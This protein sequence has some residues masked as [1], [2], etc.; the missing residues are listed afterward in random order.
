[1]A[2]LGQTPIPEAELRA[3]SAGAMSVESEQKLRS[4]FEH[5]YN[6]EFPAGRDL[7]REV[8]AAEP[9]SATAR[10]FLASAL[11]YEILARQGTLQ[12]HLFVTSNK[13]LGQSRPLPDPEFKRH[14]QEVVEEAQRLARQR[15][16]RNPSDADGLFALGLTYANLANYA[17]AVEGKHFHGVRQGEKAYK[18][19]QKLRRL[20]PEIHDT[21][22]VLG[23]RDYVTGSLPRMHRFLLFFLGAGGNRQR[24]LEYL[25]A[26]AERGEFL[27][28]YARV[29]L[30]VARIREGELEGAAR[31]LETLHADYP[32][33]SLFSLELARLYRTQRRYRQ[34]VQ[35]CRELAAELTI[36]P[37]NPRILGPEDAFLELGRAEAAAGNLDAALESFRQVEQIDSA[38]KKVITWALLE[39]GQIFDQR[40]EREKALSEYEHVIRLAA[41]PEAIRLANAHKEAPYRAKV[42][43]HREVGP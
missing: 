10:A 28:T 26:A 25:E 19:H 3:P 29:L 2:L 14:F 39:Q 22:V 33:N 8:V 1:M 43:S 21:G 13:F 37:P 31:V 5:L 34:A 18:Y 4:A 20:H 12:S 41:D 7:F 32:R 36:H 15:L 16:K 38:D 30:S 23:V 40:G 11:L 27:R 6:L 9:D 24:G 42:P 35:A 17:V